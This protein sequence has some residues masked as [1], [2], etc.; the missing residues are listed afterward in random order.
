MNRV[1]EIDDLLKKVGAL[2]EAF[3]DSGH[4]CSPR[5]RLLPGR[6]D[7]GGL[8]CCIVVFDPFNVWDEQAPQA[9]GRQIS[10][11]R[12]IVRSST[13]DRPAGM[14]APHRRRRASAR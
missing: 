1:A 3:Q 13:L 9:Y 6:V 12:W 7:F 4:L 10:L 5:I 2:T 11:P 8:A 14:Q